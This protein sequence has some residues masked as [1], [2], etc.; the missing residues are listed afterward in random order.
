MLFS[1]L[2]SLTS[3]ETTAVVIERATNRELEFDS[4]YGGFVKYR[5]MSCVMVLLALNACT[6]PVAPTA[7]HLAAANPYPHGTLPGWQP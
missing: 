3:A 4:R 7:K 1:A 5:L 2:L 6:N